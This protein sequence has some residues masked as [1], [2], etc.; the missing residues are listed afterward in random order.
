MNRLCLRY[1]MKLLVLTIFI[2]ALVLIEGCA[3]NLIRYSRKGDI[4]KV[5]NLL[6]KGTDVNTKNKQGYFF[7]YTAL[8]AA[9]GNG[10]TELVKL[11]I[12][13]GADMNAIWPGWSNGVTALMIAAYNGHTEVVKLL[14]D[15]GAD[16]DVK[17]PYGMTALIYA[18]I[19]GHTEIARL[20]MNKGADV[21]AESQYLPSVL[22]EAGGPAWLCALRYHHTE[23]ANQLLSKG[24]NIPFGKSILVITD[25]GLYVYKLNNN[26][27]DL[28]INDIIDKQYTTTIDPGPNQIEI[29]FKVGNWHSPNFQQLNF[30]AKEG[31]IYF[32]RCKI[33]EGPEF[34]KNG[35]WSV[36]IEEYS[37]K[38]S[39][40]STEN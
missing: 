40:K 1:L 8:M 19:H 29:G 31:Y 24:V 11:L 32:I 33:I 28:L 14:L 25:Y 7:E 30:N 22:W 26:I 3:S 36:W 16:V 27:L 17:N 4:T 13:K 21:N 23:T 37:G 2:S 15:K 18:A 34:F 9:A 35:S 10:H 20:L 5:R 38:K 6:D 12:D 39:T